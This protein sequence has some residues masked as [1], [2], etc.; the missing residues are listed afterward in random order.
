[1][2]LGYFSGHVRKP[3]I[4][5]G[6]NEAEAHAPRIQTQLIY[7]LVSGL[8]ASMRPRRMRLGYSGKVNSVSCKALASMRPR[9]MRLG[10]TVVEHIK[11]I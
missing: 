7:Q 6:F 5:P 4:L 3:S 11:I 8:E 1:M 2:R 9:R 10:Y